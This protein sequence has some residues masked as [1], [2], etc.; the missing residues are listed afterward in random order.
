MWPLK[1]GLG[2]QH[3]LVSTPLLICWMYVGDI[4]WLRSLFKGPIGVTLSLQIN[5]ILQ[6]SLQ[7]S[8]VSLYANDGKHKE[9]KS[10]D[11]EQ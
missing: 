4:Q 6:I 11:V 3:K 7:R 9:S 10:L 2:N 8:S 5:M 1:P